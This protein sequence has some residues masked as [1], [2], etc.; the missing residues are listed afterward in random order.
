MAVDAQGT[1]HIVWPTVIGGAEPTGALFHATTRDGRTF[2]PRQRVPTLG[3][4]K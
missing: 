3:S 2:S 4:P 1:I